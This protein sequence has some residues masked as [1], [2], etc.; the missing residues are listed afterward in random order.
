MGEGKMASQMSEGAP[1]DTNNWAQPVG[2]LK[3]SNLPAGA[4]NM[5]VDGRQIVGP[6]QG[7][8]Q[9]WQKTYRIKLIAPRLPMS[10]APATV[11]E[12]VRA[13]K[14]NFPKFWP[15]GNNFY[16]PLL[17]IEPGEVA[18]LNLSGPARMPLSTGVV[19]VYAD[20]ES[21][22]FMTP[23]GH[24]FAAL[25]TFSGYEEGG[26]LYAQVQSLLRANDPVWEISMRLFGFK[27]ED[28]FWE[29][30]LKA[31]ADYLNAAGEFEMKAVVVDPRWQWSE[32]K[33]IWHN[34]AIR[35]GLY[36]MAAPLRWIRGT[37]R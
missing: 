15:R 22:S 29:Y 35:T 23:Q 33:N 13:W 19:V 37:A 25:I 3:T 34:A 10:G 32:A 9:L 8:G 18:V 28:Q 6:L 17:N 1:K 20:D 30:T 14:A 11:T 36:T 16:A 24:M 5:N 21:F 26:K 7:F 4:I 12:M 31:L 27:K 2:K